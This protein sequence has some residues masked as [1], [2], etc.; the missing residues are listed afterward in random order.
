MI[1]KR[2]LKM[3]LILKQNG[4]KIYEVETKFQY[5]TRSFGEENKHWQINK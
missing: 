1:N 2:N 5:L 4:L 3:L